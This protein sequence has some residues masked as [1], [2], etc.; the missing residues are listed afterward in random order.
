MTGKSHG[1]RDHISITTDIR[2]IQTCITDFS[3]LLKQD[4]YSACVKKTT[5]IT[6]MWGELLLAWN[7]LQHYWPA[8]LWNSIL[9]PTK[10]TALPLRGF[11]L[12]QLYD[13]IFFVGTL[14]FTQQLQN[15]PAT[16][17]TTKN[18]KKWDILTAVPHNLLFSLF[19]R[20]GRILSS[21]NGELPCYTS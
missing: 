11:L 14:S 1:L 2:E 17:T 12:S 7:L 5:K 20:T 10:K 19:G 9:L 6:R 16:T 18:L 15:K 21:G 8:R 4:E 13:F 3:D